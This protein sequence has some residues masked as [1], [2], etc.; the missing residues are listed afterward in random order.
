M[1][2]AKMKIWGGEGDDDMARWDLRV[3]KENRETARIGKLLK[4]IVF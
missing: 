3:G 2:V 1:V 4:S